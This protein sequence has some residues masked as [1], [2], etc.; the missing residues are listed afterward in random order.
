M[1]KGSYIVVYI[2]NESSLKNCYDI[3]DYGKQKI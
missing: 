2:A 3:P 1:S